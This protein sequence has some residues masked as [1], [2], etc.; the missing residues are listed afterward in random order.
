[1]PCLHCHIESTDSDAL[2]QVVDPRYPAMRT[3]G[4]SGPLLQPP[5]HEEGRICGVCG[6]LFYPPK[7]P[8]VEPKRPPATPM[9]LDEKV[10]GERR[11]PA[12]VPLLDGSY[13][14]PLPDDPFRMEG[15]VTIETEPFAVRAANVHAP[16]PGCSLPFGPCPPSFRAEKLV[17]PTNAMA[18]T[19][20]A[21]RELGYEPL[22]GGLVMT[23]A[24]CLW[25]PGWRSDCEAC[26]QAEE[27]EK[28]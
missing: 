21:L 23:R 14:E 6:V 12:L 7:R 24:H 15:T 10:A 18:G 1:M 19:M 20:E 13:V 17:V 16:H 27:K 9:D 2:G 8:V 26:A 3:M 25:H 22:E 4:A 5:G 28:G 11:R